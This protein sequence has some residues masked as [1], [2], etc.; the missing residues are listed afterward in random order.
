MSQRSHYPGPLP[1]ASL[2]A[3][4]LF[5]M[6]QADD[7]VTIYGRLNLVAEAIRVQGA[8]ASVSQ[9]RVSN[10]RSVIGLRGEE[11][12][13]E[14]LKLVWQI[15]NAVAPDAA[16][17]AGFAT[18]DSRL[19][20]SGSL[21]TA[22]AGNW[23][24]PYTLATQ[25]FDPFYPTTAGYMSLMGNGA[26]PTASN[27]SNTVAFDRRQQNVLQYWTPAWQGW[28]GKLAHGVGEEKQHKPG[29]DPRLWSATISYED[30]DL[31]LVLA[32]ERH[33]DYQFA[34][35]HDMASKAGVSYRLGNTRIAGVVERLRYE[36][37]TGSL[38]RNAWYA[39]ATHQW[40]PWSL[41]FAYTRA[42]EGEGEAKGA[43]G[44][45]RS[46][47][48]TGGRQISFGAEYG[49]SRRTF[50]QAYYSQLQNDARASYDMAI[51]RPGA[52]PG[53]RTSLLAAG[54]RHNF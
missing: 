46:G 15:E 7:S 14:G 17:S 33:I 53:S 6:A 43:V 19:G 16:D 25:A 48:D 10:N 50:L 52:S 2:V 54:L 27:T 21:G 41:R 35:S 36:T 24:L 4:L 18:R 22:F 42:G 44:G 51:N 37:A 45:L 30:G 38:A 8:A 28:S 40:G 47:P 34:D 26:A 13:G 9:G 1:G 11:A 12:L 32:H 31:A 20:L 29:S 49:L 5:G 23:T 3:V 39:S